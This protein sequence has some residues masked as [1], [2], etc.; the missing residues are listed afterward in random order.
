MNRK[1]NLVIGTT[2]YSDLNQVSSGSDKYYGN[3][4]DLLIVTAGSEADNSV[5][6][7]GQVA[8]NFKATTTIDYSNRTVT[9]GAEITVKQLR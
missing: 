5:K 9:Q 3:Q 4:T 7:A 2:T 6:D 8:G 1:I